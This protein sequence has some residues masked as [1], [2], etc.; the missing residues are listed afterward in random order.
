MFEFRQEVVCLIDVKSTVRKS[1]Q[2]TAGI[3]LNSFSGIPEI[4]PTG[5]EIQIMRP[6]KEIRSG[7]RYTRRRR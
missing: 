4:S 6:E 7:P 3:K 5:T 1:V 2:M